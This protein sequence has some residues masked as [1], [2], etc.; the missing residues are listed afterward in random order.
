MFSASLVLSMLQKHQKFA[1]ET[2]F[3]IVF[4]VTLGTEDWL[5]NQF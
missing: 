3:L 2:S 4:A 5:I 1:E